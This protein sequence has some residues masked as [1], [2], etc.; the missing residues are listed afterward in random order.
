MCHLDRGS[1]RR[2]TDAATDRPWV[3]V[4][5][6][7]ALATSAS[8]ITAAIGV[9]LGGLDL[10]RRLTP[11]VVALLQD[12]VDRHHVIVVHDQFLDARQLHEL[13]ASL[14]PIMFSPVQRA[15]GSNSAISTIQDS[16]DRPP[17]GFGW[18]TVPS[19]TQHPPTLGFLTA[20]TIPRYGGDTLWASTA[21]I[22]DNLSE[23]DRQRCDTLTTPHGP[24]STLLASIEQH[25]GRLFA[26]T[27][28][29][30]NP[31]VEHPLVRTHPTT[32]RRSLF[33][34]PLYV[35]PLIGRPWENSGLMQ[36]LHAM[37]NDPHVQM[38]W[39]WSPGDLVIWDETSTCHRALTD[40]HPQR[41]AMLRCVTG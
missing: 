11:E 36:R 32:G 16:P 17:A 2:A 6:S 40:H 13:A 27:V 3:V 34:S 31:P 23:A 29:A 38:R 33:L 19:W 12:A 14:V 39:R 41:R 21:A 25:H 4:K 24:D 28:R 37:L 7:G 15:I 9:E 1:S 5:A 10:R 22:Y 20:V 26:D 35:R 8:R 18:H 30:Q